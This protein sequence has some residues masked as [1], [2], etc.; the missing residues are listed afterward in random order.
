MT[1][2][3]P[4]LWQQLIQATYLSLYQKNE[5]DDSDDYQGYDFVFEFESAI[6][7]LLV[8]GKT[9]QTHSPNIDNTKLFEL[10]KVTINEIIRR[11]AQLY[12]KNHQPS[13]RTSNAAKADQVTGKTVYFVGLTALAIEQNDKSYMIEHHYGSQFFAEECVLD[14]DDERRVLQIFSLP[15]FT[16]LLKQLESPNDLMVFLAYHRGMLISQYPYQN[17][18]LLLA[19]FLTNAMFYHRAADVQ[20]QLVKI[21]LLEQVEPRL[22]EAMTDSEAAKALST[23]L[24]SNAKMWYKLVNGLIK[25]CYQAGKPLPVE[26]VRMLISESMYTRSCIIEEVIAYGKSTPQQRAAGYIRHQ[27]SYNAL[28]RHYMLVF[29][30]TDAGSELSA[31]AIHEHHHDLLFEVNTQLQ[32]P[33]M[34]DIF[35]LGFDFSHHGPSGQTEVQMVAYHQVGAKISAPIQRLY[36]QV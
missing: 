4:S 10:R 25:R 36:E 30:A 1:Q 35:L 3:Q 22:L 27:H 24:Q 7:Y 13:S 26:Q 9:L 34:D 21:G 31:A 18:K 6:V 2:A 14:L 16:A 28:G 15:D 12:H 5:G 20:E 29:F 19:G 23:Q 8:N 17:E 33:V 11:H 32:K